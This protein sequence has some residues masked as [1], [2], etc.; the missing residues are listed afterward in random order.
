LRMTEKLISANHR[1]GDIVVVVVS[2]QA[3]L[4][5]GPITYGRN[6]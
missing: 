1:S 6:T 3:V 2:K 4:G 5:G